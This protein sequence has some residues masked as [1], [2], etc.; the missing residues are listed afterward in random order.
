VSAAVKFG[1]P[2]GKAKR[3]VEGA[4]PPCGKCKGVGTLPML[5]NVD[6]V[7]M[8]EC[9]LTAMVRDRVGEEIANAKKLVSS[10]FMEA[11]GENLHITGEWPDVLPHL[12]FALKMNLILSGFAFSFRMIT[13][14][15]LR[16]A[17]L[18]GGSKYDEREEED[19]MADLVGSQID[20][21]IIRLGFL[22]YKNA[23]MPG[24]L[25]TS[26]RAR[27]ASLRPTWLIDAPDMPFGKGHLAWSPEVGSYISMRY[28]TAQIEGEST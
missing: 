27:E 8:C 19:R 7:I 15:D 20:L 5:S 2:P 25:L 17:F 26:L 24:I 28:G 18:A 6:T 22:G 14:E 4:S 16:T 21:V 1:P 13:D 3:E 11:K 23:A 10:P 9:R 12:R